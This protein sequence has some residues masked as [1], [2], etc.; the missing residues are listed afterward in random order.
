MSKPDILCISGQNLSVTAVADFILATIE[1]QEIEEVALAEWAEQHAGRGDM[2]AHSPGGI[3]YA[4]GCARTRLLESLAAML[5]CDK[6]AIT[7]GL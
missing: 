2:R 3:L 7:N 1:Y 4:H 6:D 5:G